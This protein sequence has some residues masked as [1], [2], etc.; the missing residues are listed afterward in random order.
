M[1]DS[2]PLT[3]CRIDL[4]ALDHN[5]A[6]LKE[7]A[8]G[9]PLT[10]AIKANAYGHGAERI[11]ARLVESGYTTLCVAHVAEAIAL[12]EQGIRAR[13]MILSPDLGDPAEE[14]VRRGY[15]PVVC[16]LEQLAALSRAAKSLKQTV[17]IHL[18][19]DTGMGRVGFLM[20]EAEEAIRQALSLPGIE[21]AAVMSHFPRADE[22]D[23][24]YSRGQIARFDEVVRMARG[25]GVGQFHLANSAAIFDLPE[26]H[27]DLCRPGISIYG[28]K[29]SDQCLNPRTDEL[30]PVLSWRTRITQLKEVPAGTGISYGHTFVT[31]RPSLIASV[32]VG[33]G[34]GLMRLLSNRME[35]LVGG[36]R[37]P[38]IGRICMDQSLIDVTALRGKVE[39]GDEAVL[40]GSQGDEEITAD[41]MAS[42]LGTI[43]YEI[44]TQISARVPRIPE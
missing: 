36:R 7:L 37:C 11:A 17:R 8:G 35:F 23:K 26:A 19:V 32:P 22:A 40:I 41:E 15:E 38:Q 27:Y 44:V 3:H 14:I 6:L 1:S 2:R 28:L 33:Y 18:K 12:E 10:P 20:S 25:L 24:S 5:M 29:P 34:D 13:F 31:K 4:A 42:T 39:L 30:K 43:N 21:I 16:T 9:R